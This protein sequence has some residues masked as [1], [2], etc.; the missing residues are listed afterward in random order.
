MHVEVHGEGPTVLLIPGAN[1]GAWSWFRQVPPMQRLARVLTYDPPGIGR[2]SEEALAKCTRP[3]QTEAA[4]DVLRSTDTA[5]CTVVAANE[6]GFVALDLAL[7][8]PECVERLVLLEAGLAG[9][10]EAWLSAEAQ[11]LNDAVAQL[12][13]ADRRRCEVGLQL[14]P[15][16]IKRNPGSL[17]R[18]LETYEANAPRA[19][20]AAA[21]AEAAEAWV[22]PSLQGLAGMPVLLLSGEEDRYQA[23]GMQNALARALPWA[24]REVVTQCGYLPHLERAD[25][26][27]RAVMTFVQE[28]MSPASAAAR[29]RTD[30]R[31]QR[32]AADDAWAARQAELDARPANP[33]PLVPLPKVARR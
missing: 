1:M 4:L 31:G 27:N 18:L 19:E 11:A 2:S 9:A 3:A 25:A 26:V 8:H 33:L 24:R 23:P 17:D 12:S 15:G 13:P 22:A 7:A 32:L 6:G 20:V 30:A 29:W 21:Y 16:F 28:A 14:A 5:S 10:A